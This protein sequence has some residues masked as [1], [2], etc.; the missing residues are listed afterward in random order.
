M[1]GPEPQ[2]PPLRWWEVVLGGV[3]FAALMLL[4]LWGAALVG[5]V[6]EARP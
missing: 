4:C 5:W 6:L 3:G 2:V 1:W